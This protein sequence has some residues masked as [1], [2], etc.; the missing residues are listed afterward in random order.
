[1]LDYFAHPF[2]S[3]S[4]L[5][6]LAQEL[7]LIPEYGG[8]ANE[9]YRIGSLFDAVITEPD[10][11]DLIRGIIFG[12]DYEF[13]SEEYKACIDMKKSLERNSIYK[14]FLGFNPNYQKEIYQENFDF[15]EF[16]LNM[17]AKLDYFIPGMVADLKSTVA[18]SQKAFENAC[19][20]FG[21]W[22]QMWLYCQLTKSKKAMIFGVSKMKPYKVFV[23]N[24]NEGDDNW[25]K[26]E[27]EIKEL[28]FKYY[29]MK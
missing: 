28:A 18:N 8:D 3:N 6:A 17:R 14:T 2:C 27:R 19:D 1:M 11:L 23:V 22:R 7:G 10:K 20:L 26:G 9:A 12:T 24:I 16:K 21:Y 13:T 4:K 29:L 15:G 25:K 5:T